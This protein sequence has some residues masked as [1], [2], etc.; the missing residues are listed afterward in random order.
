MGEARPPDSFHKDL[1]LDWTLWVIDHALPSLPEDVLRGTA[2]PVARWTGARFGAVMFVRWFTLD[3][4]S[5]EGLECDVDVLERRQ[6]EWRWV[7]GGGVGWH[8]PPLAR[9][10]RLGPRTVHVLGEGSHGHRTGAARTAYGVAGVDAATVSVIATD[11]EQS[12]RIE[13]P[14]GA[15]VVAFDA[16]R[17]ATMRVLDANDEVLY[18]EAWPATW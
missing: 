9:P 14:F 15:F 3:R 6:G 1:Q 8:L 18:S 12:M 10:R 4:P 17:D 5:Q 16:Q 2:V 11:R 7:G 13:S